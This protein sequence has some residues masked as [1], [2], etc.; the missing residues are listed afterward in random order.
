MEATSEKAAR[1]EAA[2]RRDGDVASVLVRIRRQAAVAGS[3]ETSGLNTAVLD[4][5]LRPGRAAALLE[6]PSP[7]G[8]PAV[9]AVLVPR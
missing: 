4:V 3:D 8:A 5:R 2:L 9:E 6:R 7:L 1:V